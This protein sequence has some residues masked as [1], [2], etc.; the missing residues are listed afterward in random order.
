MKK[1]FFGLLFLLVLLIGAAI[2]IPFVFKDDII[3]AVKEGANENLNSTL[4]FSDVD[5]SLFRDFPNVSVGLE[6]LK[7]SGKK[8]FDKIDLIT[9]DRFDL[10][11]DFWSVWNGGNPLKINGINIEKPVLNVYV[12]ENGKANYDITKPSEGAESSD[13]LINLDEY[14]ISDGAIHY[15]DRG[16]D[17]MM[18][19]KGVNHMGSGDLTSTI[20]DLKTKTTADKFTTSMDGITYL[21]KVKADLDALI[22]MDL[23]KMKFTLKDNDLKINAL[24]LLAEGWVKLG[25]ENIDMDLKFKAP[26]TDFKEFLSL[27]PGAFTKGYESVKANG[28]FTFNSTVKGTYNSVKNRMPAFQ[29]NLNLKNGDFKYPDLPTSVSGINAKVNINS[30]SSNMDKMVVDIPNFKMKIGNNPI[31]G[32]FNLKTPQ[33]DPK[34]DTKFK[35]KLD[36]AELAKAMPMEGVTKLTGLID[37]DVEVNASMSQLDKGQYENV[38][39][40]GYFNIVNMEYRADDTPPV[41]IKKMNTTLSPK[42]L[43][44]KDF[45][46]KLGKSDVKGNGNIDNILAYFSDEKTMKGD[47]YLRSRNLDL[48]EWIS[49][50][51]ATAEAPESSEEVFDRFDF[52]L[53]GQAD[54]IKYEDY[55]LLNTVA[56]GHMTSNELDIDKFST[57]VGRSDIKAKGEVRNVFNYLFENQTLRGKVDVS[58]DLLDLNELMG[59]TTEANPDELTEPI[60]VPEKIDM[61][62]NANIGEVLYDDMELK[63]LKGSVSVKDEA[64][65]MKNVKTKTLGGRMALTGKYDSKDIEEPKFEFENVLTAID[66]KQAFETFNT[67]EQFAPIG[68]FISGSFSSDLKLNGFLGKDM[69]PKLKDLNAEGFLETLNGLVTGFEPLKK[70]GN[71]LNINELKSTNIKELKTWF[72][73]E[74]GK[75]AVKE[76]PYTSNGIDFKIG[77]SHSLEQEMNYKIKAKIPRKLLEKSG[78]TAAA[79]KGIKL[80]SKE[81]KKLGLNI[82]DSDFINVLINLSGSIADPK[83][84][85]KVL[86]TEDGEEVDIITSVK[87]QVEEKVEKEVKVVKDSVKTVVEEKK[88]DFKALADAEVAK[89]MAEAEKSSKR[90]RVE[91]K[92]A[93]EKARQLGYQQADKLVTAAGKNPLKKAAAKV[94]ADRLKKETDKKVEKLKAETDKKADLVMT[95]AERQA[96]KIRAKYKNR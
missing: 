22:H 52:K 64:V 74:D 58:G 70:V 73:I 86:G 68:K 59:E 84:T 81:A 21:N 75:F 13:F 83:T 15:E 43:K 55:K 30:P 42:Q 8:E 48:N 51:E 79:N 90:I 24:K 12:L 23:D 92:K 85:L 25:D 17:F 77:G 31:E 9:A 26:S 11:L 94:A 16:M 34:I 32:K 10:A 91:G 19:M 20:Y 41:T 69:L 46:M 33:S 62:I 93:A 47:L 38:D 88:E 2:A 56:V 7:I 1:L 29:V 65:S 72:T 54:I 27:V 57:K 89:V 39:A 3:K 40:K 63:E 5:L 71:L 80:I 53:D 78:A 87:N 4:D 82:G 66:F 45:D 96:D 36:L 95:K 49:E 50:E 76:F 61:V 18:D 44:L 37:A 28:N 67:F 60:L 14:S 6:N 35:G